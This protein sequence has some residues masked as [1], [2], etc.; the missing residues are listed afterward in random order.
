[1]A[2]AGERCDSDAVRIPWLR[3]ASL[4][5][6]AEVAGYSKGAVF[7]HS[8]SKE[9]LFLGLLDGEAP[10]GGAAIAH[11]RPNPPWAT[12]EEVA[13]VVMALGSGLNIQS[14]VDETAIDT[15][16]A[17]AGLGGGAAGALVDG[18]TF[19]GRVGAGPRNLRG[20]N[21]AQ[22]GVAVSVMSTPRKKD[23]D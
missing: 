11:G 3:G 4:D 18:S 2:R 21:L 8:A 17:A 6:I 19:S 15:P 16:H 23:H 12:W 22:V 1:M 5:D 7:S 13:S 10:G 20:L 9:A 14:A